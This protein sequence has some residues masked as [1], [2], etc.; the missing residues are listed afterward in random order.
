MASFFLGGFSDRKEAVAKFM[1][2]PLSCLFN[3]INFYFPGISNRKSVCLLLNL[4]LNTV[5]HGLD[6]GPTG[7]IAV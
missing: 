5:D 2:Q 3:R 1:Q 4:R 6:K 7:R